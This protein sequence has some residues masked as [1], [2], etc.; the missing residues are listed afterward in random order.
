MDTNDTTRMQVLQQ[1]ASTAHHFYELLAAEIGGWRQKLDE[2]ILH[3]LHLAVAPSTAAF[4]RH[5]SWTWARVIFGK[6]YSV[7]QWMLV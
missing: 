1:S 5:S 6:L 4:L 3:A 2:E 7:T